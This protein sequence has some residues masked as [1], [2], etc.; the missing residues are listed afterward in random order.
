MKGNTMS[1]S[2]KA[3]LVS[4]SITQW[5][6]RK[7]D[8]KVTKE[9]HSRHGTSANAGRYNKCLIDPEAESFV[10]VQKVANKARDYNETHTL[11]WAQKGL[12]ILPS[13]Q[14]F[15]YIEEMGALEREFNA[16]ASTFLA[17]YPSLKAK[18]KRDLNGLYNEA[19]YLTDQQL[20]N[21]YTF[22]TRFLPV[23]DAKD[24]RVQVGD[25]A[26][27]R[28]RKSIAEQQQR[29]TDEAMRELYQRLYDPIKN[30]VDRLSDPKG[31]FKDTLVSNVN[32]IVELLPRLNLTQDPALEQL[33]QDAM[34]L[35]GHSPNVLRNNTDARSEVAD[36]AKAIADR[37]AAFMGGA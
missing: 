25:E 22:E 18:A 35:T 27:E 14:Y 34:L 33:R 19:D 5:S 37:M 6:A 28:I 1:L 30:M 23:P 29:A 26:V 21:K 12:N 36:R 17:E 16:A 4:L 31:I 15:E 32:E 10:A 11:P 24:F 9:V 8:K 7:I 20:R 2:D 3:M 13:L